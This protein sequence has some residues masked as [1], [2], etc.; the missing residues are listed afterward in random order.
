MKI[1]HI[2]ISAFYKEG[3]GYQ[4]NLLTA[5]HRQ[6]GFDVTVVTYDRYKV[7]DNLV[8]NEKG[9]KTY[10]NNNEVKVIVLPDYKAWWL[11][12]PLWAFRSF[13]PRTLHLYETIETEAP[14]I[15]FVHGIQSFDH[16]SVVKYKKLHPEVKVFMDNHNDY[17]NSPV[18]TLK[19]FMQKRVIGRINVHHMASI[20]D[21]IWGVTPWR[22]E[23]IRDVYGINNSKLGLLVMG[24]DESLID[25][26]HRLSIRENFRNNHSIPQDAF[27][28]VTGGKIDKA[29]NIHLLI[30]AVKSINNPLLYLVVFG[31]YSDEL[32]SYATENH[33]RIINIGWVDS[34][35]VYNIF[36]S[37]DF[38]AFPGTHSVLWEQACA[39]GLPCLFKDW[40]GGFN[41]V[42]LGDNCIILKD[43]TVDSLMQTLNNVVNNK[44]LFTRMKE[45]ANTKCRKEFAY[46]EIAKRAIG[47]ESNS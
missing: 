11:K 21:K 47:L 34:N 13:A 17:Y 1:L 19:Q 45:V 30:E 26:E 14:D 5:K 41:H 23:Y 7:Y 29:K 2:M 39:S 33:P 42:D 32:K 28:V 27:V 15:I 44:E 40:N 16:E 8:A 43:I 4:E 22:V 9:I 18:K 12:L 3:Y 36:L 25:W 31:N 6:L 10:V 46:V 20:C 38:G 24:G 35:A 37:S